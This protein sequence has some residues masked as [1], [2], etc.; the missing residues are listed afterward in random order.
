MFT[1]ILYGLLVKFGG[2]VMKTLETDRLILRS[3]KLSDRDDFYEYAK[4]PNIGPNAGWEPHGNKIGPRK[5]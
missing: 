4:N 2:M 3:W 1:N 5:Y